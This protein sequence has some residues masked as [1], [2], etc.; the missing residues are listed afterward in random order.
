M[1]LFCQTRLFEGTRAYLIYVPRGEILVWGLIIGHIEWS[2]N[3]SIHLHNNKFL[4]PPPSNRVK[5]NQLFFHQRSGGFI[6]QLD[7]KN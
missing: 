6:D 3:F 5:K 2:K 7:G 4:T 1:V